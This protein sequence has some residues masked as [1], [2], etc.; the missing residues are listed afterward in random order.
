MRDHPDII[1]CLV[2]RGMELDTEDLNGKTP[3]HYAAKYGSLACLKSL[4]GS[5]VDITAG[6]IWIG[7]CM[8][9]IHGPALDS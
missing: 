3:A 2:E 9:Y 8:V 1:Q 6:I 7:T 4:V 5:K